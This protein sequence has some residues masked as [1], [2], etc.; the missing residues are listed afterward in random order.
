MNKHIL[1][2]ALALATVVLCA[3]CA[4]PRPSEGPGM[5]VTFNNVIKGTEV[6]VLRAKTSNGVPFVTP[7]SLGSDRSPNPMIGGKTTGAAPDGR[8]LP[9]WVE[10]EWKEWPYPYP[11]KPSDPVALQAWREEVQAMSRSL[12][13]KTARVPVR[14]RVPQDVVVE[15]LASNKRAAAGALPDEMLWVYFIWYESEIKFRWKLKSDCCGLLREGGDDLA[16]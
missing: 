14:S 6:D 15:V 3:V 13:I 7:G 11:N 9:E 5:T 2:P 16:N 12:P 4:A 8:E 10:F 1:Q